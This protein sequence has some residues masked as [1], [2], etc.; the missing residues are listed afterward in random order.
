MSWEL[1]RDYSHSSYPNLSYVVGIGCQSMLCYLC[2]SEIWMNSKR[3]EG[4][5][6]HPKRHY[7]FIGKQILASGNLGPIQIP[8][9]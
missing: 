4:I 8:Y 5:K 9:L 1:N 3:S 2:R 6:T 7:S